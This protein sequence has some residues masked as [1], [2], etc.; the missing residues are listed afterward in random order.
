[1]IIEQHKLDAIKY[2]WT[3]LVGEENFSKLKLDEN[4][5]SDW[6]CRKLIPSE[7]WDSLFDK[8]RPGRSKMVSGNDLLYKPKSLKGIETNN[9]WHKIIDKDS[10]PKVGNTYVFLA[11]GREVNQW[12]EEG[13]RFDKRFTHW[14]NIIEYPKPIY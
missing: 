11:D 9:G 12:C 8:L 14:R 3:I 4:G 7:Y 1:M 5:Y 6:R 10:L 2:A 13:M